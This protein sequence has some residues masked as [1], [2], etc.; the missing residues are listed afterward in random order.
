MSR[1]NKTRTYARNR[2]FSRKG[3]EKIYESDGTYLLKLVVVLLLGTFWLKFNQ[4]LHWGDFA[5]S[6]IPLGLI[7]GLFLVHKLETIQ[8][9]RKLWYAI[10]L[11]T[12]V[13]SYFL[14]VGIV[15]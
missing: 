11:I 8:Y 15:I 12:T 10:L 5:L 4:S 6:A 3:N 2:M 9:N 1:Q 13:I 7:L 14:P